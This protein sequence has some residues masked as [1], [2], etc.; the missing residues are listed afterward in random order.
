MFEKENNNYK[1]SDVMNQVVKSVN[2]TFPLPIWVEAE[3][4]AINRQGSSGHYYL[5]LIETDEKGSEVC[6]NKASIW[7]SKAPAILEKFKKN[8]GS[9]L[10]AG[11]KVLLKC[12][13]SFHA[14]YQ[15]SIS[16]ED[17]N[18]EFTLGGIELKVKQILARL[19]K[20]GLTNKNK[21]LKTPF[22]F[23][24]IA[25][26]SPSGAAG[27]GDFKKDADILE[28]YGI[29]HFEYYEALF[30]GA[31]TNKSVTSAIQQAAAKYK[32]YDALIVIRGGGAK[33]DLHYLNEFEIAAA[34][35]ATQIPVFVGVGHERDK[36][37][38]DY[39]AHTSFD[40]P[41]KVIGHIFAVIVNNAT[42]I[43]NSVKTIDNGAKT[44]LTKHKSETIQQF[45]MIQVHSKKNVQLFMTRIESL[46]E[47]IKKDSKNNIS[48]FKTQAISNHETTLMMAK[49][50]I[51]NIKNDVNQKYSYV[52]QQ[53]KNMVT[54]T[55]KDIENL[56]KIISGYNPEYILQIGFLLAK[57]QG[58][59]ISNMKDLKINDEID[60]T[61][62][63]GTITVKIIGDKHD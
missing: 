45:E 8:T 40:T 33:T 55:V 43:K 38:L 15:L 50:N 30:Q 6:K 28:K 57:K 41:S 52:L 61:F 35:S 63:D 39:V 37:V 31:D 21:I 27:L 22:D 10:K 13:V 56:D 36:G 9:E 23:S 25:V 17:I 4:V 58:K 60:L 34:I 1:L 48:Q 14:K 62:K 3:I 2:N 46:Y 59:L 42:L 20:E 11:I 47:N 7:S 29:C 24:R 19:D 18:P 32:E 5:E 53:S 16:I 12:R 54:M 26:I 44:L 49:N 51:K